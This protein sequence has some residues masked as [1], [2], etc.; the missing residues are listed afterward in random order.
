MTLRMIVIQRFKILDGA[1]NHVHLIEVKNQRSPIS[2]FKGGVL[3]H[4]IQEIVRRIALMSSLT[5]HPV[6]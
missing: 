6:R 5:A 3:K 2:N 4:Q 1:R